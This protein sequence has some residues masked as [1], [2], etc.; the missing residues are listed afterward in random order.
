[1]NA[2]EKLGVRVAIEAYFFFILGVCLEFL[3]PRYKT[4]TKSILWE[5]QCLFQPTVLHQGIKVRTIGRN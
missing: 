4:M 3:L 5:G 1:M 2:Q